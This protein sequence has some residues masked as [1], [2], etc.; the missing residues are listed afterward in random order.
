MPMRFACQSA[1]L[2]VFWRL[3]HEHQEKP[4][5]VEFDLIEKPNQIR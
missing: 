4:L 3:T 5:L 2:N 1:R